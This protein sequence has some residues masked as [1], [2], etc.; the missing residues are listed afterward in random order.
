M[1]QAGRYLASFRKI[2]EKYTFDESCH[3][4][5]LALQISLLPMKQYDLDASIVFSDILFPLRA[6]GAKLEFTNEGPK[7]ESP[8]TEADLA[9]LRTTFN[10]REDTGT[11][12]ETLKNLRKE[13]PNEKAVLGFAGAPFTMAAY[14]FEGNL[15]R[16]LGV[17][18]KW[19]AEKPAVVHR[20]LSHLADMT[21]EYLSAQ[22]ES[23]RELTLPHYY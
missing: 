2:R 16:D 13:L 7:I 10:P 23:V 14:L 1:R 22:A 12:L 19:M 21:G 11:I 18:K 3:S 9:K 5:E 4:A 17:F 15:S 6:I 8:K 20:W